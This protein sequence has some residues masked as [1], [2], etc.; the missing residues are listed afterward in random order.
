MN[1]KSI[2]FLPLALIITNNLAE[3]KNISS[4]KQDK[5][6]VVQP[7]DSVDKSENAK[8]NYLEGQVID[9]KTQV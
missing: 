5:S 9:L 7:K 4:D 1:F 2:L 6:Q 3:A 8:I